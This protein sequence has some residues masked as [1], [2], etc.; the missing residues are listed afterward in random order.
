MSQPAS[1]TVTPARKVA[2][3]REPPDSA[4]QAI[5]KRALMQPPASSPVTSI[6]SSGAS[7]EQRPSGTQGNENDDSPVR[8]LSTQRNGNIQVESELEKLRKMNAEL[9]KQQEEAVKAQRIAER[10]LKRARRKHRHTIAVES[11]MIMCL[12]SSIRTLRRLSNLSKRPSKSVS[13]LKGWNPSIDHP[14]TKTMQL[15]IDSPVSVPF[16]DWTSSRKTKLGGENS[17]GTGG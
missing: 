7:R 14:Y 9:I 5:S 1:A 12:I 10:E 6:K 4:T 3:R 11:S 17:P 2:K 16:W 15:T 8:P 13:P